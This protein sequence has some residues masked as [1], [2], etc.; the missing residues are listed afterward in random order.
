MFTTSYRLFSIL[1]FRISVDPSLLLLAALLVW[2]FGS[3]LFP[4]AV[5]GLSAATYYIMG[6]FAALGLFASIVF[7][8]L[9]HALVAR[10]YRIK[11]AGITLFI[12]G[13]VAELEDEPP[14]AKSEFFVA[15]AGP[16]SSYI[17]AGALY[18]LLGILPGATPSQITAIFSYLMIINII[19]AT[20]NLVPAFPLDGGRM[21][22]AG[23]WWVRGD[24]RSA[25]RIASYLGGGLGVALMILGVYNGLQGATIGGLWQILIGFF[26]VTAANN[27]RRQ[28]EVLEALRGVTI[29]SL[30]STPPS[31]I[32]ADVTVDQ[33]T[34]HPELAGSTA[35]YPVLDNGELVGLIQPSALERMPADKRET[36]K[37]R[38]AASPL[39]REERL[40]PGQSTIGALSQ[41]RRARD[42]RGFVMDNGRLV[43]WIGAGDIFAHIDR[44]NAARSAGEAG[45][46][47]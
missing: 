13:G 18:V 9:A 44:Q 20:F 16:I 42:N 25:T 30:M 45:T 3:D 1:G 31:G 43:G 47:S 34:T 32:P 27:A 41:L 14:T 29:G 15:I 7:H 40:D 5:P 36:T 38:E 39:R 2:S 35:H 12:F 10:H 8:E 17:L 33:I 37:M 26:I 6:V 23:L 19:L 46:T 28:I 4:A 11:I 24:L 22:R 21:L